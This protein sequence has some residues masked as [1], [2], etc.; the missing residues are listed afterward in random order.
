VRSGLAAVPRDAQ[1]V[2]VH[3]AARPLASPALFAAVVD[4][5]R[6]GADCAVPGVPVSDTIKRVVG[7]RVVTTVP[8]DGLVA[9]QTPQAF[10]SEA[11]RAAHAAGGDATDDAALVEQS[12]G[13]VVVVPGDPRNIKVTTERDLTLAA[14]VSGEAVHP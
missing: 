4:A 13:V 12:G 8:R 9:V 2:V 11:L 10:R 3:D 6:H 14:A 5:V 7:D 1:I